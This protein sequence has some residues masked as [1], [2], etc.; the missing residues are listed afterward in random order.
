MP[1]GW[2][3]AHVDERSGVWGDLLGPD[4]RWNFRWLMAVNG[5]YRLTRG[6]YAQ[7]G[8][9]VA[10]D[11]RA[12]DTVLAHCGDNDW[13]TSRERNACNVLDV[14]HPLWM[15]SRQSDHR[16]GEIRAGAARMLAD[17]AGEW[18]DGQGVAWDVNT[19]V[20][21]LQGTEMWMSIVHLAADLVGESGGLSWTPRGVHRL[22]PATSIQVVAPDLS[23]AQSATSSAACSWMRDTA[24]AT[25]S[26]SSRS[27][28]SRRCCSQI[29]LAAA[30]SALGRWRFR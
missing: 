8:V 5:Y 7:F 24:R 19:D 20:P 13:F 26:T 16:A 10:H 6:S 12:I 9:E 2:L 30:C 14:I 1:W 15:L 4:G 27:A 25:S 28:N 17:A 23:R 18:V 29:V 22:E 11:D 3:R 21:G